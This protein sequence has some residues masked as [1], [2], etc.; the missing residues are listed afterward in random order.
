[1]EELHRRNPTG[2]YTMIPIPRP[3]YYYGDEEEGSKS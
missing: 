3:A 2:D 1:M